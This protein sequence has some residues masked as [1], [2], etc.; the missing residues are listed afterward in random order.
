[1]IM[2]RGICSAS[3]DVDIERTGK[4]AKRSGWRDLSC[5]GKAFV[6]SWRSEPGK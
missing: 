6:L 2:A 1:V 4:G 5:G 3:W